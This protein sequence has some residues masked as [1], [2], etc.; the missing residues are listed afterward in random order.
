MTASTIRVGCSSR[1]NRSASGSP[2][3][4]G[5]EGRWTTSI[6]PGRTPPSVASSGSC[7]PIV[8]ALPNVSATVQR[9]DAL[10][11]ERSLLAVPGLS[12]VPA[13]LQP[14]EAGRVDPSLQDPRVRLR[15]LQH[16]VP[17]ERG[18][19][20]A[21]LGGRESVGEL[22]DPAVI[23]H[24]VDHLFDRLQG[25]VAVLACGYRLALRG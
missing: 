20:R 15:V 7:G 24:P 3:S 5:P 1:S 12:R 23:V 17:L 11:R 16:E 4:S 19:D 10:A 2:A 22:D 8:R 9:R 21:F 14:A 25:D 18:Q 13:N 6:V